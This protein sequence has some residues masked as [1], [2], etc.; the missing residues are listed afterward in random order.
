[1]RFEQLVGCGH[2]V[3]PDQPERCTHIIRE[4]IAAP[5]ERQAQQVDPGLK[6]GEPTFDLSDIVGCL[7]TKPFAVIS[8]D[9]FLSTVA[10]AAAIVPS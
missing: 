9:G 1:M 7:E 8:D 4:F 3:S 2:G 5:L 6:S 10:N